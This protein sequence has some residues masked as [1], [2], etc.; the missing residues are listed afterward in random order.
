M[1]RQS[2]MI[3][4]VIKSMT[5]EYFGETKRD[6]ERLVLTPRVR[7][8]IVIEDKHDILTNDQNELLQNGASLDFC[9]GDYASL[10]NMLNALG[11]KVRICKGI[12]WFYD[13]YESDYIELYWRRKLR[14]QSPKLEPILKRLKEERDWLKTYTIRGRYLPKEK[15][16]EL[17]PDEMKAEPDGKKYFE[18]L[19]LTTFVHEAMHAYFD[20]PR[21]SD[22][23]YA[24]L[25]EE[26]MA[27]FGMLLWLKE[28][29]MPDALQKWAYD[30]VAKRNSCYRYGANLIDQYCAWNTSLRGYLEAYKYRISKYA[31]LDVDMTGKL[32]ALPCPDVPIGEMA[33]REITC[34]IPHL[35]SDL[36]DKLQNK[37]YCRNVFGLNFPVLARTLV[38]TSK[39][40]RYYAEPVDGY[41]ICSEW[42]ERSRERLEV[43]LLKH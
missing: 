13:F 42:Y 19:L 12:N 28:T 16:I 1:Y 10:A 32:V 23:T 36:L 2:H 35:S 4:G 9:L 37:D 20:R 27:E 7:E 15:I 25:V 14:E 41:Y 39:K 6:E 34:L 22:Y 21:H 30:V 26:P 31:M 17:Y 5:D 29:I 38:K 40:N 8:D 33:K 11:V 24:R 18:Y 43:W 3:M